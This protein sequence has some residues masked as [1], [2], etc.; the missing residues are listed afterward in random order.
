MKHL[1]EAAYEGAKGSS[2]A[3]ASFEQFNLN[4]ELWLD[5]LERFRTFLTLH[6]ISKENEAQVFRTNQTTVTYKLLSNVAAQ[7]SASKGIND[8]SMGRH[9]EVHGR[10]VQP[11]E[12][13]SQRKVQ[14]L[15]RFEAK[16]WRDTSGAC[17]QN[18]A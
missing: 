16:T 9:S 15:V 6:S 8:L 1:T 18:T 7:Q 17:Q 4:S 11:K 5:C 2:T 13:C 3:V 12:I 10:A 14:I